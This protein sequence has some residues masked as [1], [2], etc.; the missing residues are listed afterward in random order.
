MNPL[1]VQRLPIHFKL[2]Q[3]LSQHNTELIKTP[4]SMPVYEYVKPSPLRTIGIE[5]R[6]SETAVVLSQGANME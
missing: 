1:N 3:G 6:K 5:S 2:R 4:E